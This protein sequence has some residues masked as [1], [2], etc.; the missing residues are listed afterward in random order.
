MEDGLLLKTNLM[1][2]CKVQCEARRKAHSVRRGVRRGVSRA[3]TLV[4]IKFTESQ[5]DKVKDT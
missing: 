4:S 5:S 1:V 2:Q 3:K